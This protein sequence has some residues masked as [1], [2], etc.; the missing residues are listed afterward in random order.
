MDTSGN[1]A[2]CTFQVCGFNVCLQDDANPGIVFQGNSSTGEYRFCCGGTVFTGTA[3]VTKKGNL[4]T[5]EQNG[6][7]RRLL[8]RDDE[9]VF[10]GSAS[11]QFPPGVMR[12]TI[13]DRDTRNNSCTCQSQTQ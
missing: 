4:I 9:S 13:G 10:R 7:D 2:S 1:Q 5:F 11:L 12:C 8:V 3:R 6:P